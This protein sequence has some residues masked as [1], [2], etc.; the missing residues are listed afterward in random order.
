[1]F[2]RYD[3]S[4]VAP[5]RIQRVLEQ[6]WI[7]LIRDKGV[8]NSPNYL[9]EKGKP[10]ISLWGTVHSF[11]SHYSPLNRTYLTGFGFENSNH[12]PAT[13]R[14]ITAFFR[15]YTPGGAFIIAGTPAH[16]R[17][18]RSDA[19]PNPEF[20]DIWLN[21]FDALS[22]WTVGRY[23]NE[24]EADDFAED[25]IKPDIE[26]LKKRAE[27][28]HKKVDY[29]PVVLPGGSVSCSLQPAGHPKLMY[30][31]MTFLSRVSICLRVNGDLT[32]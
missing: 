2:D 27:E 30:P 31:S 3:V 23:G 16:W 21:E 22:P 1:M 15:K 29:M 13:I 10:V 4:G 20:L 26:L 28:G 12:N 24:D 7:H 5:D 8:L 11:S 19:D 9:K 32:A 17:T 25:K 6:D 18:S 14:A